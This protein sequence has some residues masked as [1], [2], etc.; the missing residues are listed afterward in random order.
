MKAR[1][2]R[3]LKRR[4]PQFNRYAEQLSWTQGKPYPIPKYIP[5]PIGTEIEHPD[6]WKLVANGD[7][8]PACPACLAKVESH[9][10]KSGKSF[11][12]GM[13]EAIKQRDRLDKGIHPKHFDAYDEGRMDGYDKKARPVLKGELV[14]LEED[15]PE[16]QIV[17]IIDNGGESQER[18]ATGEP[19]AETL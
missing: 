13:G 8:E 3:P 14:E 19:K 15:Q 9:F 1:L 7:A 12:E 6:A 10:G 16:E 4:N 5:A 11:V 2:I 18:P 17:V